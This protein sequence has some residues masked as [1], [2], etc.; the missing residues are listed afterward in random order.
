MEDLSQQ[1][2]RGPVLPHV[3]HAGHRCGS[4]ACLRNHGQV[5]AA[6]CDECGRAA[7]GIVVDRDEVEIRSFADERLTDT[8]APTTNCNLIRILVEWP[9]C[10][11]VTLLW[12]GCDGD[13]DVS[14]LFEFHI[15]AIF[16]G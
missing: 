4:L 9:R 15:I 10:F 13:L 6:H 7:P 12:F 14:T 5:A 2:W 16:V 1:I 8:C 11:K 3:A